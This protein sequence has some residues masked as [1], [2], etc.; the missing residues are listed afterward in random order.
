MVVSRSVR[1]LIG[2]LVLTEKEVELFGVTRFLNRLSL[3]PCAF[4]VLITSNS[5]FGYV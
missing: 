5:S 3:N 2:V 4:Y 1:S